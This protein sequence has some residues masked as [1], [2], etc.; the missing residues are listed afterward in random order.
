MVPPFA[1]RTVLILEL[2]G[3]SGLVQVNGQVPKRPEFRRGRATAV[4]TPEILSAGDST[5]RTQTYTF[6]DDVQIL[7]ASLVPFNPAGVR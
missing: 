6:A 5:V 1:I 7:S 4:N 3:V 2:R